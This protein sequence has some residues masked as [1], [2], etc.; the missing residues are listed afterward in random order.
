MS[1]IAAF[2][3]DL[4]DFVGAWDDAIPFSMDLCNKV[5]ANCFVN[6]TYDPELRNGTCPSSIDE[7]YVG[8]SWEN[9]NNN[10]ID[11]GLCGVGDCWRND[12]VKYP[13]NRYTQTDHW[14]G[15]VDFAVNTALNWIV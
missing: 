4:A 9:G 2:G 8:F 13:F 6:A 7:F 11:E 3:L 10:A 14:R 5:M 15:D 12:S 1:T